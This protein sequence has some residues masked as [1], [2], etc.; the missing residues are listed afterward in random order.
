MSEQQQPHLYS[1]TFV[2]L[3]LSYK[4]SASIPHAIS[5]KRLRPFGKIRI[6]NGY[7]QDSGKPVWLLDAPHLSL[8]LA[9]HR[10]PKFRLEISPKA[11][12]LFF[13]KIISLQMPIENSLCPSQRYLEETPYEN[14]VWISN[15]AHH[16]GKTAP[17]KVTKVTLGNPNHTPWTASEDAELRA[18]AAE[19][20]N[21]KRLRGWRDKPLGRYAVFA[22]HHGRT[23]AAVKMRALRV[24]V[25]SYCK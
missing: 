21:D 22:Q 11:L 1:S 25:R 14:L 17:P 24:G 13:Q 6:P 12:D 23:L 8:F 10:I 16:G 15:F 4:A 5:R 7:S 3:E 20:R 19:T 18:L 2:A 9:C